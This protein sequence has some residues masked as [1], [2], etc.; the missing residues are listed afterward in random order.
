MTY[1]T[2]QETNFKI[3]ETI[4]EDDFK[5]SSDRKTGRSF[6]TSRICSDHICLF[7]CTTLFLLIL[8]LNQIKT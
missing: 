6:E 7:W 8:V 2:S 4:A 1:V 5:E 3:T